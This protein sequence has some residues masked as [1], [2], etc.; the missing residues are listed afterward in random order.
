MKRHFPAFFAAASLLAA[1]LAWAADPTVPDNRAAAK[2][3][4][5][6]TP[7]AP[8]VGPPPAGQPIADDYRIGPQD[9]IEIQVYGIDN[10]KRE[11]RVNSRGAVSMPLVGTVYLGGLTSQEAEAVVASKYEKDDLQDPQVSVFIKEFTSQRITIEGAVN[12]P[13]IFPI[14][15]QTTLLQAM[16][17]AGGPGALSD[18]KEVMVYRAEGDQKKVLMYDLNKIRAGEEVDPMLKNE[19]VIVL[20]R[21]GARVVL[22]DSLLRDV[23]DTLNPF[24]YLPR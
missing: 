12:R 16:A 8:R 18:I 22:K 17:I 23:V 3:P 19:D 7:N 1:G 9:L 14:R 21:S 5:P 20:K 15:G 13:G 10:L 11:V 24:N 2:G 6:I 4:A